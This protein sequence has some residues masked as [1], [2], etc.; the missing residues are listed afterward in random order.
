MGE[1]VRVG[2]D[3]LKA[4]I[5]GGAIFGGGGG[6][7]IEDGEEIGSVAIEK[8][9]SE[10]IPID[11]LPGDAILLTV[12]AVG[13]PSSG[14]GILKPED[15]VRAVE[16]L[17]EKSGIKVDGLISS[18]V[19]AFGVVNGWIQSAYLGIP[20]VD[21][22][23]N[24]RAHP[25]GLMGSMGLHRKKDYVSIQSA[26]GGE[27]KK[28][29]RLEAYYKGSM[30]KV[31]ELVRE[32]A[33]R[34]GGMV[35]VARN[36]VSAKYVKKNGAPGAIKMAL[37]VGEIL[38]RSGNDPEETLKKLLDSMHGEYLIKG[39]VE[40]VDLK[41]EGGFD[42]GRVEIR[43]RKRY[44]LTALNEY[45][46]LERDGERLATFP[47]LIMTFD[48]STARP[49]ISA[50][51]KEKDDICIITVPSQKLI[52]GSGVKDNALLRKVERIVKKQI[53]KEE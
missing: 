34:T 51:I 43:G 25:L 26:V 50:E 53:F 24:G 45:I 39:R 9:F 31:S 7:W 2:R 46:T 35:A 44:E 12:S 49:V 32:C 13:A 40:K 16:L 1:R 30:E 5:L 48:S 28:G 8:G 36:P 18:E 23:C 11:E 22:P 14:R 15:F 6:G 20:V 19:G 4:I 10:I 47:D 42:I 21:A 38:I 52:I 33:V 37:K 3:N 17:I 29:N 27:F 41:K